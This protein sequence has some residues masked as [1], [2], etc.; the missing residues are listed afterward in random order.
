MELLLVGELQ[1]S[2]YEDLLHRGHHLKGVAIHEDDVSVLARLETADA[3]VKIDCVGGMDG[4]RLDGFLQGE[5]ISDTEGSDVAEVFYA[6]AAGVGLHGNLSPLLG[7][8][9]GGVLHPFFAEVVEEHLRTE[10][11]YLF[12][13]G[14]LIGNQV[15]PVSMPMASVEMELVKQAQGGVHLVGFGGVDMDRYFPFKGHDQGF[16]IEV[17]LGGLRLGVGLLLLFIFLPLLEVVLSF[18]ED[19]ASDIIDPHHRLGHSPP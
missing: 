2:I 16:Q 9:G 11:Q 10:H 12:P 6:V 18:Q 7:Q 14:E 5:T 13:F 17:S 3:V 4:Y 8:D 19:F 15:T 1:L